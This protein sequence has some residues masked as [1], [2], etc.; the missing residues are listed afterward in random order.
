MARGTQG[1]EKGGQRQGAT[2]ALLQADNSEVR[3]PGQ[4]NHKGMRPVHSLSRSFTSYHRNF[5]T[6]GIQ[7]IA[8]RASHRPWNPHSP[9]ALCT[10]CNLSPPYTSQVTASCQASSNWSCDPL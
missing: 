5:Q 3:A 7:Q 9:S 4:Q 8:T 6:H 10:H 1:H 2:T